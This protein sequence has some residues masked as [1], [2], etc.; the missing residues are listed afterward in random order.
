MAY[1]KLEE[2][3]IVTP[4]NPDANIAYDIS[5]YQHNAT[6]NNITY[7]ADTVINDICS[8]FSN[9]TT[10]Y[11]KVEDT[12]WMVNGS[13]AMTVNVWGYETNW[14][15][16]TSAHFFSCTESGG[17]NTEAGA[18][19][20]LRFPR[21]V[22]TNSEQTT[23]GYQYNNTGLKLADLTAGWHMLTFVYTL[24]GEK[25]YVD[26][27]LHSEASYT[28]YGLKFNKN[29]RLFLGCEA[30]TGNPSSPYFT[31]MI[32]DF[33]L[34]YTELSSDEILDLYERRG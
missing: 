25:I 10:S 16:Q 29:A 20:Y 21:Y 9:S 34:Y 7:S 23:F 28:S 15:S 22:A 5:G 30:A 13:T 4:W 27:V 32:S 1:I 12:T 18:S 24:T 31:G 8:V 33:R 11:I 17:F 2:G 14:A 6:T 26:G 3:S 19:G